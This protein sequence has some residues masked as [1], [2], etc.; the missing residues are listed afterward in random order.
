MRFGIAGPARVRPGAK[1]TL[2]HPAAPYLMARNTD[3][4]Y[5][6]R[7]PVTGR[8]VETDTAASPIIKPPVRVPAAPDGAGCDVR[9]RRFA[10]PP[11]IES[12]HF[13]RKVC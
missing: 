13:L 12:I 8:L 2:R 9:Q 11:S 10:L 3:R 1:E 7:D 4:N 5:N 6:Y